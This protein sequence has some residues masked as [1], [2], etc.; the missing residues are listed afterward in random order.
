IGYNLLLVSL[1][2]RKFLLED[3]KR[4]CAWALGTALLGILLMVLHAELC[5]GGSSTHGNGRALT[6]KHARETLY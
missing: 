1:R 2:D 3:K 5:P 6:E 4:L